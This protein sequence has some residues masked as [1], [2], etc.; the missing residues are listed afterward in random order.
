MS[1]RCAA[2]VEDRKSKG[3]GAKPWLPAGCVNGEERFRGSGI[4]AERF[5]VEAARRS[6]D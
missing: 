6:V 3:A 2:D 5:G 4:G 1:F